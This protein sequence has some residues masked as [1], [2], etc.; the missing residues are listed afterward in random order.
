MGLQ[1]VLAALVTLLGIT[2]TSVGVFTHSGPAVAPGA[3]LAM[4]GG[5]WLGTSLARRKVRLLPGTQ[6]PATH[7]S[8]SEGGA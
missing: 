7:P 2:L 3:L 8:S 6:I 5:G 4:V 1:P